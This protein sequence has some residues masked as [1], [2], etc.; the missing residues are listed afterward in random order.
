MYADLRVSLPGERSSWLSLVSARLAIGVLVIAALFIWPLLFNEPF[1]YYVGTMLSLYSIGA[2]S[3]H[4]IIRTGHVS[5]CQAAFMGVASYTSVL[6]VM[7]L[8]L[9]WIVAA[10]LGIAASV[11]LGIIVAPIF[12]RLAG[13]Y[14]VL[15]TFLFGEIIRM[16]FV[17]WTSVTGGA[18][19][20][21][22]IP[23]PF[24][25]VGSKF[26]YYYFALVIALC[27]IFVSARLLRSE[28]GQ[29][30]DAIRED[31]RLAACSGIPVLRF[32]VIIF[33]IAC[34][35]AG[36]EGVVQA[37]YVRYLE[38][39][40]FGVIASLNLVVM[41]VIGGMYSLV[42]PLLGAAFVGI[43]PELLRQY[44]HLQHILFGVFLI[45]AMAALPGGLVEA[46]SRIADLVK[47]TFR[48]RSN[49]RHA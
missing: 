6:A 42:G 37:H 7:S 33:A 8:G 13:K 41:N 15:V 49:G 31:E 35:L 14:F 4:L 29:T 30:L 9:P 23:P 22:N 40:S 2:V 34:A 21:S 19:G 11:L 18:N 26:A 24:E 17:E 43:L 38:P 28:I 36:V 27:C 32:K 20:I 44:V 1:A 5:M 12:L 47:K 46:A 3:V 48:G 45:V 39:Q 10:F 16:V 25:A